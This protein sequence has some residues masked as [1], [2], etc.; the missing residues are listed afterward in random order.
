VEIGRAV[1]L[2]RDHLQSSSIQ[3]KTGAIQA[4]VIKTRRRR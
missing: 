3:K 2:L 4:P 1:K